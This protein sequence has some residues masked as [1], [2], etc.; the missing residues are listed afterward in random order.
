VTPKIAK[1]DAPERLSNDEWTALVDA[2]PEI[3]RRWEPARYGIAMLGRLPDSAKTAPAFAVATATPADR[4]Y[5]DSIPPAGAEPVAFDTG[6]AN[7]ALD[8]VARAASGGGQ[9]YD[10]GGRLAAAGEVDAEL[11]AE[12]LALPY[13]RLAP[14]KSTGRELFGRDFTYP[15]IDRFRER[16]PDLMATL[17]QLTAESVGIA[18]ERHLTPLA[19]PDRVLVSGGGVHNRDLMGRLSRRLAPIPVDSLAALGHDPDAKEALG[20]AVLANETLFG[21]PGNVPRA[22]GAA[23]PRVL[24]KI[25]LPPR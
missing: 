1:L 19:R 7:M 4:I 21:A 18:L 14:P 13:F 8:A 25:S 6:P 3:E 16:L 5:T 2:M 15:L 9:A 17:S 11:L 22:T 20:F 23:G 10:P 24:G 12:L